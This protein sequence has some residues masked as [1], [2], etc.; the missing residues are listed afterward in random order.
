M[1]VS[2]KEAAVGVR[3]GASCGR[4]SVRSDDGLWRPRRSICGL[5]EPGF[6]DTL[7][8]AFSCPRPQGETEDV[9]RHI[10]WV[11]SLL[12]S[13]LALVPA[14]AHALEFP[15]KMRL[16]RDAQVTVQPNLIYSPGFNV[17]GAS[18][19]AGGVIGVLVLLLLTPSGARAFWLTPVA[20]VALIGMRIVYWVFTHPVNRF[21]LGGAS[22][23][24]SDLG[25][26]FFAFGPAVRRT[27]S[28][29]TSRKTG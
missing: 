11:L 3:K 29:A 23:K 8:H 15:G 16:N 5:R 6:I 21:W 20:P 1:S 14:V 22:T 12:L 2:A 9:S 4:G 13:A 18:G 24:V 17:A 25:T 19:E 26:R 28:A 27:S 10:R 7:K